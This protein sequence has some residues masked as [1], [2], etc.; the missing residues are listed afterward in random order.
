MIEQEIKKKLL[1]FSAENNFWNMSMTIVVVKIDDTSYLFSKCS[2][3]NYKEKYIYSF[4][5]QFMPY[6][7]QTLYTVV[8]VVY[9]L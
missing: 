6:N 2:Q 5:H 1:F 4:W 8:D 9:I 3:S 7:V